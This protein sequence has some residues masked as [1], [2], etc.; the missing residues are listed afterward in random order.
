M[1]IAVKGRK[2]RV[3]PRATGPA[4]VD[5]IAG[6]GLVA[7]TADEEQIPRRI[8]KSGIDKT[9]I[10]VSRHGAGNDSAAD[11]EPFLRPC[12]SVV[13]VQDVSAPPVHRPE[14]PSAI[15]QENVRAAD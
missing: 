9:S 15:Y 4:R 14:A 1:F 7:P 2:K 3:I 11:G 5:A 12:L 10:D 8:F 6:A 13:A